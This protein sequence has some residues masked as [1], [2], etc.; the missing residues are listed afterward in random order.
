MV[1]Y[2]CC[3]FL[4]FVFF[5]RGEVLRVEI[6]QFKHRILKTLFGSHSTY[7]ELNTF[8]NKVKLCYY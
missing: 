2:W 1:Q 3:T 5:W 4:V 7:A 8:F 6:P